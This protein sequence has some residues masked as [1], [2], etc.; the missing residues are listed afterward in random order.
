MFCINNG[1]V[2]F[3]D[4]IHVRKSAFGGELPPPTAAA[5]SGRSQLRCSPSSRGG[6]AARRFD[7][8][9][10]S[11]GV[12]D[13]HFGAQTRV[14]TPWRGARW[15][16]PNTRNSPTP[17]HFDRC[18]VAN[19]Q[20]ARKE[21]ENAKR[22]AEIA[23]QTVEQLSALVRTVLKSA[24]TA[25]AFRDLHDEM[26]LQKANG[27]NVADPT[28]Y[29]SHANRDSSRDSTIFMSDL[30]KADIIVA[31]QKAVLWTFCGD[32]SSDSSLEHCVAVLVM[33]SCCRWPSSRVV[34]IQG[35]HVCH[36]VQQC[37]TAVHL[38]SGATEARCLEGQARVL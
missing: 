14:G 5:R 21:T 3:V 17:V 15:C 34:P 19:G 33:S 20:Q 29:G 23:A 24:F 18:W 36:I 2:I 25:T 7:E 27:A 8:H 12:I 1:A 28:M 37:K 38:D 13:V 32:G 26:E 10:S 30:E 9:A 31:V 22:E 35:C 6:W 11:L 16:A 4:L